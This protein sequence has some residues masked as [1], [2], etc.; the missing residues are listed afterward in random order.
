[1]RIA[2]PCNNKTIYILDCCKKPSIRFIT[3]VITETMYCKNCGVSSSAQILKSHIIFN[4]SRVKDISR[5]T[6]NDM[7]YI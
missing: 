4:L 5:I 2:H 6:V 3:G 1:M 7:V